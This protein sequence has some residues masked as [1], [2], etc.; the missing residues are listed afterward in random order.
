MR[1]IHIIWLMILLSYSSHLSA[2]IAVTAVPPGPRFSLDDLWNVVLTK[3]VSPSNDTWVDLQ[4]NIYDNTGTR[5]LEAHTANFQ[6]NKTSISINKT[7]LRQ[8]APVRTNYFN[9][10]LE[11]QIA[12]QG[13]LFPVGEYKVEF[14]VNGVGSA[15]GGYYELLGSTRY[16]IKALLMQPIKLVSVYNNDTIREA[17]PMFTWL[18]PYPIPE[19]VAEY[20]ITLSEIRN[21]QTPRTAIQEN[22]PLA[23]K[24]VLNQTNHYYSTAEP[25]LL[26]GREYAWQ[27]N[28][29]VDGSFITGSETWRFVYDPEDTI[30]FLPVQYYAMNEKIQPVPV[31]VDS[32]YLPIKFA[33]KFTSV[34]SIKEVKIY[35]TSYNIVAEDNDIPVFYNQG[36][37]YTYINMCPDAFLLESGMYI[38]E[39]TLVN[40]KLYYL[41]FVQNSSPTI[42]LID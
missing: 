16:Q 29:F 31:Y 21:L 42:C 37:N 32:N 13:G 40:D 2:Q 17:D 23:K 4:L 18:P 8:F 22:I 25:K 12:K 5:I 19:G 34:D 14:V 9:R 15:G 1:K 7:N 24:G 30:T 3:S 33:D 41:R 26:K 39:I 20:E 27:V 35:N 38:L 36:K 11:S 28:L 6:F 10:K